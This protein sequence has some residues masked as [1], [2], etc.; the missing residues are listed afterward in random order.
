MFHLN[1]NPPSST[2][3][4][5]RFFLGGTD[6][7]ILQ[8]HFKNQMHTL[9]EAFGGTA[10]NDGISPWLTEEVKRMSHQDKEGKDAVSDKLPHSGKSPWIDND[11]D[12]EYIYITV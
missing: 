12:D 9:P 11:N 3:L 7:T 1:L 4:R 10:P 5:S 6:Y 8:T 2:K